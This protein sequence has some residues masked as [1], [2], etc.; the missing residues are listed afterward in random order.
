[1][2]MEMKSRNRPLI[3][4]MRNLADSSG[5]YQIRIHGSC[6]QG[7]IWLSDG[8]VK[9]AD[10]GKLTGTMALNKLIESCNGKYSIQRNKFT[11]YRILKT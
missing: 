1:M 8:R 6:V 10:C 9:N 2:R 3:E 11:L 4:Y 5:D 7:S